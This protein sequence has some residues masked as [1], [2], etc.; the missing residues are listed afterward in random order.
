MSE[1]ARN[2]PRKR[3][4]IAFAVNSVNLFTNLLDMSSRRI[5]HPTPNLIVSILTHYA[6]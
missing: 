1:E 6:V 2:K 5:E 3:R 4:R